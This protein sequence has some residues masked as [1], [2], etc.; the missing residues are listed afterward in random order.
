MDG[1]ED[2]K[3]DTT[4]STDQMTVFEELAV[5]LR[6]AIRR[7]QAKAKNTANRR[8]TEAQKTPRIV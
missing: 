7:L 1:L 3:C 2:P 8:L 5:A 6:A 4:K